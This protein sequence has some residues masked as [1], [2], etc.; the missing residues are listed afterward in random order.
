MFIPTKFNV[1]L[2]QLLSV[3]VLL[4]SWRITT[5]LEILLLTLKN[6]INCVHR[7]YN[8]GKMQIVWQVSKKLKK[9]V[10]YKLLSVNYV[11]CTH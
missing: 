10:Q 5:K 2:Y 4:V 7:S 3:R 8:K 9:K 11:S 1:F 6:V